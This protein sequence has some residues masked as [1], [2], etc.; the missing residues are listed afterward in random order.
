MC[1]GSLVCLPSLSS[2]FEFFVLRHPDSLPDNEFTCRRGDRSDE[3]LLP[4]ERNL[5][6][7]AYRLAALA[8]MT[9]VRFNSDVYGRRLHAAGARCEPGGR[10][11]R[12]ARV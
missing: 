9:A 12:H 10:P 4:D 2:A 1:L 3:R 8:A 11:D 5:G 7:H 6:P